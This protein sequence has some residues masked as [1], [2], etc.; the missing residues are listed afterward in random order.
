M[1]TTN[2]GKY[3]GIPL[4]HNSKNITNFILDEM[5]QRLCALKAKTFSLAGHITFTKAIIIAIQQ[6]YI[7]TNRLFISICSLV[8]KMS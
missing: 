2:L 1:L 4:L 5:A 8:E 3:L 7:Q 6:Y